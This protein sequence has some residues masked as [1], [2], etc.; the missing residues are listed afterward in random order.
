MRSSRELL[1]KTRERIGQDFTRKR[2]RKKQLLETIIEGMKSRARRAAKA[3]KSRPQNVIA[4][5]QPETEAE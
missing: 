1:T 2:Q 4:F 5:R 3:K